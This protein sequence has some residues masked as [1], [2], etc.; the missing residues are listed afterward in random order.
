[1]QLFLHTHTHTSTPSFLFFSLPLQP[2][3]PLLSRRVLPTPPSLLTHTTHPLHVPRHPFPPHPTP[4]P[5][6][7]RETDKTRQQHPP[8]PPSLP[9]THHVLGPSKATDALIRQKKKRTPMVHHSLSAPNQLG[10]PFMGTHV[11]VCPSV[12]PPPPPSRVP[13]SL[14][15]INASAATNCRGRTYK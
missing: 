11:S 7:R 2:P 15:T 5:P 6:R 10:V 12:H 14:S 3:F 13:F 4:P 1:M 9:P 8:P